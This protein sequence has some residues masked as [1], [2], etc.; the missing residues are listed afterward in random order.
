MKLRSLIFLC[1]A[2]LAATARGEDD[3]LDRLDD[4]LTVSALHDQFRARLSGTVD[5]EGY[6][7]SGT[8]PGL[9]Y[10]AGHSLFN[11]RLTLF[12]DA[13]LGGKLYFFVQT[14]TDRGRAA[15]WSAETR[16][17]STPR[18]NKLR[19]ASSRSEMSSGSGAARSD[20]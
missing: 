8:A 1:A 14:R 11:P 9:I 4:A 19:L 16:S 3:L 6:T 12:V 5:A 20:C 17:R 13:Q 15:I 18:G 7:F 10:T 2:S